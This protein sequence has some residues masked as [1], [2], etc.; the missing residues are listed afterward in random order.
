MRLFISPV[1]DEFADLYT[2]AADAYNVTPPEERNSGFDLYCNGSDLTDVTEN[3]VIV[4]LGC[5]ALAVDRAGRPRAYWIAPRSSISKSKWSLANSLGLIDATYRGVLKAA[6]RRPTWEE[7]FDAEKEH[8][9]RYCQAATPD[10][11]PWTEII[12]VAELP[13]P[14]TLRGEGGFGST[15]HR[16]VD[17]SATL[18]AF[19][20]TGFAREP[21]ATLG[22]AMLGAA[23]PALSHNPAKGLE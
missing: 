6:L 7:T 11:I 3:T 22:A 2:R 13:G 14:A 4:G 9:V 23:T 20:S 17:P 16:P 8:L 21:S 18:G 10:L 5:R 19:G 15:G 1:N 12:V